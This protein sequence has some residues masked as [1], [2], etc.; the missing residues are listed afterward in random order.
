MKTKVVMPPPGIFVKGNEYIRRRGKRIQHIANGFWQ[1]WR[2]E[3]L[4]TL[5]LRQKWSKK[6]RKCVIG[7]I[8]YF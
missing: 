2:K 6:Q 4:S 3:F 7:D 1:R 8:A 5:Q